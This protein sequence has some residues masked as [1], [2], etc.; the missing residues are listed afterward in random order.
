M[1]LLSTLSTLEPFGNSQFARLAFSPP[2]K[3]QVGGQ[4]VPRPLAKSRS[5]S[6]LAGD[7]Q[8]VDAV[9]K[10]G[11]TDPNLYRRWTL[12]TRECRT[13]GGAWWYRWSRWR[14][15]RTR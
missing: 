3:Y 12:G 9:Q 4:P 6:I 1:Y 2:A 14:R 8:S 11:A 5:Y 7:R 10:L 15:W 13:R